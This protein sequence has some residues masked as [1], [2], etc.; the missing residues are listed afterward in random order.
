MVIC[1]PWHWNS[2][3]GCLWMPDHFGGCGGLAAGTRLV[4]VVLVLSSPA[5]ELP[6]ALAAQETPGPPNR[7]PASRFPAE[8]V[9]GLSGRV[10]LDSGPN[11]PLAQSG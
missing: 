10:G 7:D 3:A 1:S 4:V 8:S 2:E 6:L 5:A 9:P 11:Y